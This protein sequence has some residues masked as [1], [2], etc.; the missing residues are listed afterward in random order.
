MLVLVLVLVLVVDRSARAQNEN[1]H[2]YYEGERRSGW[3]WGGFGL[4]GLGTGIGMA[5]AQKDFT[6]GLAGPLI[7]FGALQTTIGILT[8]V[9]GPGRIRGIDEELRVDAAAFRARDLE[10]I[11]KIN[12][13]FVALGV[14]ESILIV[15][16]A[17]M[18]GAGASRDVDS[19]R[20]VG[21]G[22]AIEA[23]V[24]LFCDSLAHARAEHYEQTLSP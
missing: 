19:V 17:I 21:L 3:L 8:L 23:G 6:T 15:S 18:L 7:G 11:Q 2:V 16:G 24:M 4:A 1:V 22:V 10:R 13:A 20:G 14:V 5:A 12:K 9:R